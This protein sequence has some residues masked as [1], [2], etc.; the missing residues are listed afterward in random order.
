M[1]INLHKVKKIEMSKTRLVADFYV[2]DVIFH[3]EEFNTETGDMITVESKITL[4]LNEKE[5]GKVKYA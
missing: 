1:D 3:N 5:A 2:R 4:F